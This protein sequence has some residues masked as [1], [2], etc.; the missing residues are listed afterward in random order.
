MFRIRQS[1]P[2]DVEQVLAVA[3]H[4]DTVNLPA[5]RGHIEA[6]LARSGQAFRG[7]VPANEREYLFEIGRAHV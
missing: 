4:L 6:I 5:D 1:S 7:E 3:E 2:Q